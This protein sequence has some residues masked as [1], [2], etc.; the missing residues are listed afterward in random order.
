M[1]RLAAAALSAA[2]LLPPGPAAATLY[3]VGPGQRFASIGEVPWE[4][5]VAG[6][7]VRIHAR[8]APYAEKWVLCGKGTA[9]APIRVEGVP[10]AGGALP[11]ITGE[12]AT[13]RARLNFWNEERALLKIGGANAPAC[14]TPEWVVVE[15][16]H[17]RSARDAYGFTGRSGPSTYAQNAAAIFVEA[18]R[19]VTLRGCELED[20]GNGLFSSAAVEDLVVEGCFLHGNGNFGSAFEHNSYTAGH[21]VR[22]QG[23]RYGPPCAGCLGNA[24]KD[25][26]AGTVIRANWIE[27]GNRQL[28]LVDG[29]DDPAIV[30]DPAYGDTFVSGNVLV[31]PD[32]AGN[33]QIVHFGGD[34]GTTADYRPRLWF[35]NNTVVSTRSGNTTLFRLSTSA[36][37]A[38]VFANVFLV[39]AAGS[40][41]AVVEGAG[42]LRLGGNWLKAGW[43]TTHSGVAVAVADAGGNRTGADPGFVDLAG[44][45]FSLVAGSP[46]LDVEVAL[47]AE[48]A[49]HPL[50]VQYLPHQ[51]TE[52]RPAGGLRD[53]GAFERFTGVAPPADPPPDAPGGCGCA[54]AGSG[55]GAGGPA[56]LGLIGLLAWWPARR[57]RR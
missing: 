52:P 39:T 27:G 21:R 10:D 41:L 13:T 26:S 42:P 16:L 46:A 19:H 15:K 47:P 53:L 17:L 11:V 12:G 2:L 20:S 37:Q 45:D 36:Q 49:A 54:G 50:D 48:T 56:L 44:Q 14:D 4:A 22:F 57:R 7:L 30:D 8:P 32:G 33:S 6:D 9:A 35:W 1:H 55:S 24:L 51:A 23:N 29:E 5:L 3:Q 34:S 43:V 25:R 31:E 28:D 18:G 40:R 38:A